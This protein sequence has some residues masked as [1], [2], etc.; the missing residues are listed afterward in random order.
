MKRTTLKK[1]KSQRGETIAETLLAMLIA[2]L[3]LTML[4]GAIATA[5]MIIRNSDKTMDTYYRNVSLLGTGGGSAMTVA[6][7]GGV[8]LD[9]E[10]PGGVSV[11]YQ[12]N[13]AFPE[14]PVVAYQVS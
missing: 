6:I 14:K 13:A 4:A 3:A 10:Q 8:A 5:N 9:G 11:S 7:N 2:A 1:L 12:V